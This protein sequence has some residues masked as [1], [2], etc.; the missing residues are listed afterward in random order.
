MLTQVI[1]GFGVRLLMPG[2]QEGGDLG[3]GALDHDGISSLGER[4][5]VSGE[6]GAAPLWPA[7]RAGAE[8]NVHP[9]LG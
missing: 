1:R 3:P 9:A 6:H 2:R 8:D 7:G 5:T 4:A